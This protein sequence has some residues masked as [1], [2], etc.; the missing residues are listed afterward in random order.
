ML[1]GRR[2]QA[3][4]APRP[5]GLSLFGDSG[6]EET[7]VAPIGVFDTHTSAMLIALCTGCQ[8]SAAASADYSPPHAV[9]MPHLLRSLAMPLNVV[10]RCNGVDVGSI[11]RLALKQGHGHTLNLV[12]VS[13]YKPSRLPAHSWLVSSPHFPRETTVATFCSYLDPIAIFAIPDRAHA[14]KFGLCLSTRHQRQNVA[15]HCRIDSAPPIALFPQVHC[16][17]PIV[18]YRM[19]GRHVIPIGYDRRATT[20]NT[21]D[22]SNDSVAGLM[23]CCVP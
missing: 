12:P 5:V 6:P 18:G 22:A 17:P 3:N 7:A 15:T 10:Y 8:R 1:R 13:S 19:P 16:R 4:L 14:I 20:C 23:N 2:P 9:V 11:K 21:K